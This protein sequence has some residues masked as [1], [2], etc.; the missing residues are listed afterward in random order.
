M[1]YL[2]ILA[3]SDEEAVRRTEGEM[4]LRVFIEKSKHFTVL[5]LRLLLRKIHLPRQREASKTA[6]NPE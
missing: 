3:S 4:I 2:L 5:S 6:K 1:Q